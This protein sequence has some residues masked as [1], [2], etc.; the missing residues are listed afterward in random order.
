MTGQLFEDLTGYRRTTGYIWIV[1]LASG[2]TIA[3]TERPFR[4]ICIAFSNGD[5]QTIL[6]RQ[7]VKNAVRV[8][9]QK[10]Q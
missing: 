2:C 1:L 7:I 9:F 6:V 8:V 4:K 5:I 10:Q 3:N